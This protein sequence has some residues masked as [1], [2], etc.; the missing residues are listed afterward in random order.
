MSDHISSHASLPTFSNNLGRFK[1][2]IFFYLP[3]HLEPT[4]KNIQQINIFTR[5]MAFL[6]VEK[7]FLAFGINILVFK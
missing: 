3:E 4:K 7:P 2:L 1:V 5:L 6:K